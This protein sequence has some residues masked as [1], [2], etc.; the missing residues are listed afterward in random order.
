VDYR[1]QLRL[2]L[3]ILSVYVRRR[4]VCLPLPF[5]GFWHAIPRFPRIIWH[6]NHRAAAVRTILEPVPHTSYLI[7]LHR[8]TIDDFCDGAVWVFLGNLLL[9]VKFAI[10]VPSRLR[11]ERSWPISVVLGLISTPS[12]SPGRRY[13]LSR[14]LRCCLSRI[15]YFV[16]LGSGMVDCVSPI[17]SL[18]PFTSISSQKPGSRC[19]WRIFILIFNTNRSTSKTRSGYVSLPA[20]RATGV[21]AASILRLHRI[22]VTCRRFL[23]LGY[24]ADTRICMWRFC[25]VSAVNL[26]LQGGKAARRSNIC[27]LIQR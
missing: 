4:Q 16:G 12:D 11:Y 8:D 1:A 25:V 6:T 17:V 27:R 22:P 2:A 15:L 21:L 9:C 23:L 18:W 19:A 5:V 7:K 20:V 3:G 13:R 24:M 26:R 10:K 14:Q